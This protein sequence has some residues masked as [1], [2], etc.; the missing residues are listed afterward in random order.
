MNMIWKY[1]TIILAI[2]FLSKYMVSQTNNNIPYE[3]NQT[4]EYING[5]IIDIETGNP[6][7]Y[8]NIFVKTKNIG[9]VSNE[10]GQFS[11]NKEFVDET[12]TLRFQYI[13]YITKN[14][15]IKNIDSNNY[16]GLQEKIINLS[17][18]LIFGSPPNPKEIVKKVLENKD[19]NYPEITSRKMAFLRDRYD[20][21][22][23][24]IDLNYKK[25]SIPD[26]D[27]DMVELIEE[28][29]PKYST[30]YTDFLGN[31]YFTHIQNDSSMIKIEPIKTVSL[32]EDDIDEIDR[33][34]SIFIQMFENTK[35]DEY[36]KIKTGI[37]STKVDLED[38][39]VNDTIADS[40]S[41]NYRKLKYFNYRL[42]YYLKFSSFE[43]TK[44]WEFLHKT[45]KYRYELVGGT[46]VNQED[47]YIID[48]TPKDDGMYIGRLYISTNT[49]AL[50]R[51]DYEYAP[52]QL[53]R[54]IQLFGIGYTETQFSGSIYFEKIDST[55][56]LKYFSNRKGSVA[57]IERSFS[58]LKKRERFLFDKKVN[59]IKIGMDLFVNNEE[60]V[61]LLILDNEL[62]GQES[63]SA[64]E[65]DE[66]MEIIYVD[67]FDDKLWKS[68]SIIEPTKQMK[69]YK[70]QEESFG[71]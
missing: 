15:C 60:S 51:A 11:I 21:N 63:Y 5:V 47:V 25:S 42:S 61:E 31:I 65:Q 28:K 33:L 29:I 12:D 54:D 57:S 39:S 71:N 16:V 6:L 36:W 7:P 26:I 56:F 52:E 55:Y 3:G 50:I 59:E 58:L 14:I 40:I 34:E 35:E 70:K 17:E 4:P 27:D 9:V 8:A 20:M 37:L 67:Q 49:Y 38:N 48:F 18:L 24:K 66:F 45:S 68:Y 41:D 13:G 43:N 10:K 19:V 2:I 69:N 62:I 30:S 32:K 44:Q 22:I 64:F 23:D 1:L 46:S 53:G